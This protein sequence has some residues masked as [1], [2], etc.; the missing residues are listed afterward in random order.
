MCVAV[1]MS[2]CLFH[3]VDPGIELKLFRFGGKYLYPMI[4]PIYPFI[5][6]F[7]S[8]C[9]F[10]VLRKILH[11]QGHKGFYLHFLGDEVLSF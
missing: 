5:N 8:V 7:F 11:I 3:Q 1:C 9:A 4:H 2:E 6:F 10:C